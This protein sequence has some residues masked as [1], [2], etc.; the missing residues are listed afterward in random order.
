MASLNTL[1]GNGYA[2]IAI[3][4]DDVYNSAEVVDL[5]TQELGGKI[6]LQPG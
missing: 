6:T 4:T 5:V 3:G 2:Q 1:K